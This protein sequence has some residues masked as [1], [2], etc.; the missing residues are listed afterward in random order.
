MISGHGSRVNYECQTTSHSKRSTM[1]YLTNEHIFQFEEF[2]MGKFKLAHETILLNFKPKNLKKHAI[3]IKQYWY[4]LYFH[5][6]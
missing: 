2:D 5:N 1:R 3:G 4:L 6:T